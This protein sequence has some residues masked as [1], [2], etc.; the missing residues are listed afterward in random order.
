[1]IAVANQGR[2]DRRIPEHVCHR[3]NAVCR[4]E[5]GNTRVFTCPY[6]GWTYDLDGA[7]VGVPGFKEFY[8]GGLDKTQWGL[9]AQRRSRAIAASCSRRSIARRLPL[10]DYLGEVGRLGLGHDRQPGRCRGRRRHPEELIEAAT[11]SSPS[12][13]CTTGITRRCRTVGFALGLQSGAGRRERGLSADEPDG[14]ARRVRARHRRP[15]DL[16]G[17]DRRSARSRQRRRA[18]VECEPWRA[19]RRRRASRTR[20]G[21]HPHARPPEH[22]PQRL[23]HARRHAALPAP[24]ARPAADGALVVHVRREGTL[25]GADGKSRSPWRLTLFGPAG[26][27]SRTTARTGATSTKGTLGPAARRCRSTSRWARDATRCARTVDRSRIETVVNEHGQ[28]WT[29]RAG[30][31]GWTPRAGANSRPA[32]RR[33]VRGDLMKPRTHGGACCS[34]TRSSSSIS[35]GERCWTSGASTSGS[36]S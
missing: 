23:D 34:S 22:L 3:G 25:P 29:Y 18:G 24:A 14:A 35:R 15:A 1:M 33:P 21:R 8:R 27:S 9:A 28:L 4:A 16:G 6:H 10:D 12:T 11:G 36:I 31:T 5:Q 13:T 20:R 32:M 2:R 19:R 17:A 7:L 26:F 30:P